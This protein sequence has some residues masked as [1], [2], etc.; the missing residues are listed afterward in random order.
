MEVFK[1]HI[2]ILDLMLPD[3]NGYS[4][5]LKFTWRPYK[6]FFNESG[7]RAV[8]IKGSE[9]IQDNNETRFKSIATICEFR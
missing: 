8:F 5:Y 4:D 7:K 6:I 2:V 9:R 3:I 1:P